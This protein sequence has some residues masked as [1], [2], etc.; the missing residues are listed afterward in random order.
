MAPTLETVLGILRINEAE[1][2]RLGV[3]HVAVFGSVARGEA[4]STSDVDVLLDLDPNHPVGVFEYAR[5][6]LYVEEILGGE[7]DVV[8][9]KT[10]KPLLR[11]RVLREAVNA[12]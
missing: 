7:S 10:L 2:R 11:S 8:N 12:F 3:C 6:K 1:L 4:Q 9:R 5:I